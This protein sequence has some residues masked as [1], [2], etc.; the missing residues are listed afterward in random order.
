MSRPAS[1]TKALALLALILLCVP[2]Q[3]QFTI[4]KIDPGDILGKIFKVPK[5]QTNPNVPANQ[6]APPPTTTSPTVSRLSALT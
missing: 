5:S 1:V 2:A 4:P 3:A 6:I